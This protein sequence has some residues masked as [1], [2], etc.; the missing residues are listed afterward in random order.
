M[1]DLKKVLNKTLSTVPGTTV[2]T[3]QNMPDTDAID[4]SKLK[5]IPSIDVTN[6]AWNGKGGINVGENENQFPLTELKK[7]APGYEPVSN[8]AET[9]SKPEL[10]KKGIEAA[11]AAG[12]LGGGLAGASPTIGPL[13]ESATQPIG[14]GLRTVMSNLLNPSVGPAV[15]AAGGVVGSDLYNLYNQF[16]PNTPGNSTDIIKNKNISVPESAAR[17]AEQTG[18]S[19]TM[20]PQTSS[21]YGKGAAST[22]GAGLGGAALG[23][24]E[25]VGSAEN[26]VNKVIAPTAA[27]IEGGVGAAT[28]GLSNILSNVPTA[29]SAGKN[30]ISSIIDAV[31]GSKKD[32]ESGQSAPFI[33]RILGGV[34]DSLAMSENG[35]GWDIIS[36]VLG[37]GS[38]YNQPQVGGNAQAP[39]QEERSDYF[40]TY[41]PNV[42]ES[43][44]FPASQQVDATHNNIM[45]DLN[46]RE[47]FLRSKIYSDPTAMAS[48]EKIQDLR[49]KELDSYTKQQALIKSSK[50]RTNDIGSYT[51]G[52]EDYKDLVMKSNTLK[53]MDSVMQDLEEAKNKGDVKSV[54]AI[55]TELSGFLNKVQGQMVTQE[56]RE[57]LNPLIQQVHGLFG[58]GAGEVVNPANY[59]VMLNTIKAIRSELKN[60]LSSYVEKPG[61]NVPSDKKDWLYNNEIKPSGE[62][63]FAPKV[64]IGKDE[65]ALGIDK[66]TN[67]VLIDPKTNYPYAIVN[68]K[69]AGILMRSGKLADE[70]KGK[71]TYQDGS[72]I[73]N[74]DRVATALPASPATIDYNAYGFPKPDVK[75][76]VK[77]DKLTPN[78]DTFDI[79]YNKSQVG[80]EQNAINLMN[81]RNAYNTQTEGAQEA[82]RVGNILGGAAKPLTDSK[83]GTLLGLEDARKSMVESANKAGAKFTGPPVISTEDITNHALYGTPFPAAQAKQTETKKSTATPPPKPKRKEL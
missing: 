29:V 59:P 14:L 62:K 52:S 33:D 67:P 74:N 23:L 39:K 76:S 10:N 45:N 81:F 11:A 5:D 6:A 75:N 48:L 3:T 40:N 15:G 55:G 30:D 43:K 57:T 80:D 44:N 56:Q 53:K 69:P 7:E 27:G 16:K 35:P 68:G 42:V 1:D 38:I 60:D 64:T 32:V 31:L 8:E 72:P 9:K 49:N 36:K 41:V 20:E 12:I 26:L 19:L 79:V 82:Q 70:N 73:D 13:T 24:G 2:L 21:R 54:G 47:M 50:E 66:D 71:L 77:V 51:Q 18:K 37:Q 46:R 25:G 65:Y 63:V 83:L 22:I 34:K 28:N 78:G 58:L 61:A 17:V 4:L